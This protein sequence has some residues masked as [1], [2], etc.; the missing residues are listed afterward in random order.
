MLVIVMSKLA[1]CLPNKVLQLR[2]ERNLQYKV[3]DR[4]S[5]GLPYGREMRWR[6]RR[7]ERQEEQVSSYL[8]H[9]N[10]LQLVVVSNS[11]YSMSQATYIGHNCGAEPS[12]SVLVLLI[13]VEV[14]FV[15][16][17]EV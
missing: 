3:L 15:T 16:D 6:R 7:E 1:H 10:L 2:P 9:G 17:M 8:L 13:F 4:L 11:D 12:G 5:N 14:D